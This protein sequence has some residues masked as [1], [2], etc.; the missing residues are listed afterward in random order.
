[1]AFTSFHSQCVC[2][3]TQFSSSFRL[4]ERKRRKN[5]I[6]ERGLLNIKRQQV[7]DRKRSKEERELYNR[8]RVF[9]R[10]HSAE[11]HE[12]LLNGLISERKLRQRIE[13]LQVL[14]HAYLY[15]LYTK[16]I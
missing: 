16:V 2:V 9:M 15:V 1:M 4:D 6:L 14:Y 3:L 8:S 10:Y 5:F 12:A 13:E 7:L 11:E